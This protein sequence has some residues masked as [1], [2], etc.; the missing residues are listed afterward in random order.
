MSLDVPKGL[1]AG[2]HQRIMFWAPKLKFW[3]LENR[4]M[5]ASLGHAYAY[6]ILVYICFPKSPN[7]DS[8]DGPTSIG[9]NSL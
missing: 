4:P 7:F 8:F 1:G 2:P 9:H 5:Y 6:M 3:N